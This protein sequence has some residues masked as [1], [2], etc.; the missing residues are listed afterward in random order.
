MGKYAVIILLVSFFIGEGLRANDLAISQGISSPTYTHISLFSNG[1]TF[2]NPVGAAYEDGYR[3]TLSVD[4]TTSTSGGLDIGVGDTQ[5]GLGLGF[6]SNGCDGCEGYARANLGAIWG[7]F[8]FGFGIQEDLYTV[9]ILLNPNGLHRIGFIAE[10]DDQAGVNNKRFASGVGYA[11]VLPRF[12]FSLDVSHRN[13][14]DP[15]IEDSALLVT[16][17]FAVK[18]DIFSF[19]LSYDVYVADHANNFSDQLWVGLGAKP[20]KEWQF[21]FYGEYIDRWTLVASYAF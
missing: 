12:S 1:F 4:G 21:I 19:S 10:F 9:G 11:Y 6:Y 15:S 17:G 2:D 14:E 8:G 3:G 5:Y 18:V 7:G 16:P 20:F 13:L